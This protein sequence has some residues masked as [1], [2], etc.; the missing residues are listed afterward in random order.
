MALEQSRA[1]DV[2][3]QPDP[4]CALV[5]VQTRV[6]VA[7]LDRHGEDGRI[8]LP[9]QLVDADLTVS[10]ANEKDK[11]DRARQAGE[12]ANEDGLS[13]RRP[14][15]PSKDCIDAARGSTDSREAARPEDW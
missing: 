12:D 9:S 8:G 13:R 14:L 1:V 6:L 3:A 4:G 11:Q 10:D 15:S 5:N 7:A 2:G